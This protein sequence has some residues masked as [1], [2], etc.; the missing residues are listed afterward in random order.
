MVK[1]YGSSGNGYEW[2]VFDN[3]RQGDA[4]S[5]DNVGYNPINS[6][7]EW[8]PAL[9]EHTTHSIDFYGNGF[10]HKTSS[11]GTNSSTTYIYM[12]FAENPQKYSRGR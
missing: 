8:N 12:A 3:N 9:D 5:T 7:L 11:A 10:R 1:S 4:Q 6:A 2:V